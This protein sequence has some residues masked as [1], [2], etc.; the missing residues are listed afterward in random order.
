[1]QMMASYKSLNINN[2][3]IDGNNHHSK[4]EYVHS[5]RIAKGT[6]LYNIFKT[7]EIMVNSRHRYCISSPGIHTVSAVSD[8]GIIE[9]IE[10]KDKLFNIGVQWHPESLNDSN[11]DNLFGEFIEAAKKTYRL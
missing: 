8:D 6:L 7:E 3:K 5:V 2:T 11:T 10:A 1:M 9:G 4:E